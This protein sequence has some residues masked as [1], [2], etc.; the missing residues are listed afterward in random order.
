MMSF[1]MLLLFEQQSSLPGDL[2]HGHKH[3]DEVVCIIVFVTA[4]LY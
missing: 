4:Y 3:N 1:K 2:S